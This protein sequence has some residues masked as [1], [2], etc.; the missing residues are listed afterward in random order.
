MAKD[1]YKVYKGEDRDDDIC[2]LL[3][4]VV[5][6]FDAEDRP[7]RE[8]QVRRYRRLKL[9]WNSFSMIYW[10]ETAHDYRIYNRDTLSEDTDQDYYDRPVNVFKAFL[11]TIIAALSIQIPGINCVP[12]D[13]DNPL[14]K[15]TA[16]AGEQIAELIYKHN[17]VMLIWLQALY[18]YCTEG[19]VACYT[20]TKEDEAYGTY[21]KP[22]Y[23]NSAME[24]YLCPSCGA[25]VP[26]ETFIEDEMNEFNPDDED[27]KLHAELKTGKFYCPECSAQL[28]SNLQKTK[29]VVQR[30]VG[31]TKEPKSRVCLD[32]KGGLYVKVAQYAKRQCDTPYLIDAYETHYTNVLEC[33]PEL[34]GEV[35]GGDWS[36]LG[37]DDPY[38]Q[39][40][41]LNPQYRGEFPLEQVTVKNCWLRCAAFN[42]LNEEDCKRLKKEFPDGA[43]V[44]MANNIVAEYCNQSLDDHWTLTYNPMS[45]YLSFDPLG[46][47]L[48]NI[49]DII[50]DLISLTLQTIEQGI[51]QTFADPA[52]V[53]FNAYSQIE[54]TPGT[55]TPTKPQGG[56]KNIGEGFYQLKTA[57]LSAEVFQFYNI[58]NELGQFV[59]G[60]LPSLFGGQLNSGS[61]RTAKE[62]SDS[63][64][65]ALQRLQTPWRMFA[66]WWKEVFG[67][68]IPMYIKNVHEDERYVEKDVAGNYINVFIKKADL[69]GKIG[70]IELEADD[71]MPITDEQKADI[72]MQLLQ[73]NNQEVIDALVDPQNLPF[74][75]DLI[76]IPQFRLPGEE[77]RQKQYEE[78]TALINSV[79]IPPDQNAVMQHQQVSQ[80][81]QQHGMP[82]PPPPQPQASVQVDPDVDNHQVEASICKSW[83]ISEAGRLAKVDNPDG[84]QNVL[85]HMKAHLQIVQQQ[86][87]QQF[88]Q[89]IQQIQ[90]GVVK[91]ANPPQIG[92][93]QKQPS[94]AQNRK[95][96]EKKPNGAMNATH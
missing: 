71:R 79:P 46:E 24:G 95:A 40:S 15:S 34:R 61:S 4:T 35:S 38:E 60:A 41:R 17:N 78:I 32:V 96:S 47:L 72:I 20:Y 7:T 29:Y 52:V 56:A 94:G 33:Y 1:K 11:E 31:Y 16:K 75:A 2:H 49:Q 42:V 87:Q 30:M 54:A 19:M 86:A 77:D 64:A 3:E 22:K 18:I 88:Q 13:A 92:G 57:Q 14:D 90:A 48:T 44:V 36:S 59:S 85:L 53:N 50:N 73:I 27:A 25:P 81:A 68:A 65:Q 23:E 45:D 58:I 89:Q 6:H 12:D 67:K 10:D 51:A 28:D 76:K 43:K 93:K 5:K 39:Y 62:Y 69:D 8:R 91:S 63:R 21:N 9:Y 80:I 26:D 66:I 74:I 84:Y 37:V 55:I 83:L 82:A 70:S